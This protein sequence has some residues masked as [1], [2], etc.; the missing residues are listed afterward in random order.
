MT[1]GELTPAAA[2]GELDPL[3]HVPTRLKIVAALA[4]RET[5]G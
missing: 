2:A 5:D 1:A 4:A 3:M